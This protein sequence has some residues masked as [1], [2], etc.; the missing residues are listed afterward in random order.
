MFYILYQFYLWTL[1]LDELTRLGLVWATSP[2]S[3]LLTRWARLHVRVPGSGVTEHLRERLNDGILSDE[4]ADEFR[5]RGFMRCSVWL[6]PRDTWTALESIVLGGC[7]D[8]AP[9]SRMVSNEDWV[10]WLRA[11]S[12][13]WG[14][15]LLIDYNSK[16]ILMYCFE[17]IKHHLP[18]SYHWPPP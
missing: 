8:V 4:E 14:C 9:S 6:Y 16:S 10:D 2:S 12:S 5:R 13:L 18:S 7:E 15:V 11:R 3:E 17:N 1:D